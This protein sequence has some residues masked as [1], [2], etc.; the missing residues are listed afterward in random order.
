MHKA[1]VIRLLVCMAVAVGLVVGAGA[2]SPPPLAAEKQKLFKPKGM[3]DWVTPKAKKKYTIAALIPSL[4]A[5][6]WVNFSYG[7]FDQ[8][9]KHGVDLKFAATKSYSEFPKQIDYMEDMINLNVDAILIT[10][11]NAEALVPPVEK[12]MAKGIK[13]IIMAVQIN[14]DNFT[15][16]VRADHYDSGY[17]IAE[18]LFKAMGGDGTIVALNGVPGHSWAIARRKGLADAMKK[19]PKIKLLG[20]RWM[21]VSR[22]EGLKHTEDFL[23]A[24][25]DVK[26]IWN[27]VDITAAGSVDAVKAAGIKRHIFISSGSGTRHA[28]EM[29]KKGD[30][31]FDLGE[32][33]ILQG[34]WAVDLAIKAL[35]GEDFPR[36]T[37]VPLPKFTSKNVAEWDTST[38]WHPKGWKLPR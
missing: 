6:F 31:D 26:G 11:A 19:F 29:V 35:Q 27:A 34:R 17:I 20:E 36:E 22:V 33:P 7:L 4:E 30:M 32:A 16:A 23:Q 3:S 38:E 28:L 5:E 8:A 1:K 12:A 14:T 25:P 18:E 13:V 2:L 15:A 10:P 9:K 37:L 21:G 24:F